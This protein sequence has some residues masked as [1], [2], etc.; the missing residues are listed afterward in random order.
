MESPEPVSEA[1]QAV[2]VRVENPAPPEA[3]CRA[4]AVFTVSLA[5]SEEPRRV[6][7]RDPRRRRALL[8]STAAFLVGNSQQEATAGIAPSW[9]ANVP[10]ELTHVDEVWADV[11]SSTAVVTVVTEVRET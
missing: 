1:P 3:P 6:L 10:L 7:G 5:A 2:L 9:P 4:G 11:A 8:I